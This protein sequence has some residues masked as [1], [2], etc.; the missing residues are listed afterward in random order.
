MFELSQFVG[1]GEFQELTC[2]L[3]CEYSAIIDKISKLTPEQYQKI[4]EKVTALK[5]EDYKSII[6]ITE[7]L[8]GSSHV[9]VT[10]FDTAKVYFISLA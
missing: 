9:R 7:S 3:T 1:I 4:E 6:V 10:G 8:T 2:A 5:K